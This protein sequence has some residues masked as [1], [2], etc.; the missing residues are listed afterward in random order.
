MGLPPRQEMNRKLFPLYG[1]SLYKNAHVILFVS[2]LILHGVGFCLCLG[3]SILFSVCVC[4][5]IF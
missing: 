3:I 2:M 5:F 1:M 4:G